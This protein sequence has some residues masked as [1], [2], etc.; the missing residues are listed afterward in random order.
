MYVCPWGSHGI[1]RGPPLDSTYH[2]LAP[3]MFCWIIDTKEFVG[4]S[5][6]YVYYISCYISPYHDIRGNYTVYIEIQ[7]SGDTDNRD[8]PA[9][10]LK[11]I[12]G[13]LRSS[14]LPNPSTSR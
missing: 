5:T 6:E 12:N 3:E 8:G 9:N 1:A 13:S 7:P 4:D 2:E 11:Q 10:K 14:P